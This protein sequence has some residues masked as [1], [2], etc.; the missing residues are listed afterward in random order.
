MVGTPSGP[1]SRFGAA[2][3]RPPVTEPISVDGGVLSLAECIQIA[4]NNNPQVR[5]SW[6][7]TRAA[8]AALGQARGLYL[9][10]ADMTAGMQRSKTQDLVA[11]E[12]IYLTTH[13]A[14]FSVRQLLLDGGVREARVGAAEAALRSADFRHNA[15]LFDMA[16]SVELSYY[17]VLAAQSYLRVAEDAVG[18]RA[19]HLE[20]AQAREK[21]GLARRVDVL[22]AKAEKDDAELAVVS[23]RNQV[24]TMRG[25][26]AS[27]MGVAVS[28]PFEVLDVPEQ[29]HPQ[30]QR[31]IDQLIQMAAD[32]RPILKA[33]VADVTRLRQ[34]VEAERAARWPSVEAAA[35]YGWRNTE[36]PPTGRN[37]RSLGLT[38]QWPIF[39]GFQRTYSIRQSEA[40]LWSAIANYDKLLRDA[41]LEVWEAFSGVIQAEEAI[42]AAEGFVESATESVTASE[43]EYEHGKATIVELIDAQTALTKAFNRKVAARLGW[44]AAA[45]QLERA[46]GK[47]RAS[48]IAPGATGQPSGAPPHEEP[49]AGQQQ[50][51]EPR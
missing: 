35:S 2:G 15:I 39:T 1:S 29:V 17:N 45:A 49:A 21:A 8:A 27:A 4:L 42:R 28:S 34:A 20:L 7:N 25:R 5:A 22:Q 48:E 32:R 36:F 40:Q 31:D 6:Q 23:A 37:E 47:D 50:P 24:R 9:P 13:N 43:Q 30:E 46:I 18:Q 38:L 44:Y 33:A 41:A 14:S 10:Q 19:R 16:L 11:E 12:E 26:L 51:T 3:E